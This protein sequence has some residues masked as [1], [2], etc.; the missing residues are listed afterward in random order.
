MTLENSLS[1]STGG[2]GARR[3]R[4]V[5]ARCAAAACGAMMTKWVLR[6]A[7]PAL[8]DH[9]VDRRAAAHDLAHRSEAGVE[10]PASNDIAGILRRMQPR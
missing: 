3:R 10:L 7:L 5:L 8:V 1:S 2:G 4:A 9:A 6:C